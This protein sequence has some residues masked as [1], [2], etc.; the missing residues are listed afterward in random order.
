MS[1]AEAFELG[2]LRRYAGMI[3]AIILAFA[4]CETALAQASRVKPPVPAEAIVTP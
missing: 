1:D 3:A 4:L 2:G